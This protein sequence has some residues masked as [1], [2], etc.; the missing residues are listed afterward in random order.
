MLLGLL[1][2]VGH[3]SI[4]GAFQHAPAALLTPFAYLQMMWATSY[5]FLLFGQLPDRWSALG[6]AIIVASG[7]VLALRERTR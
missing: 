6:M 1:A 3:W 5:G 4:I 7:L 2:G